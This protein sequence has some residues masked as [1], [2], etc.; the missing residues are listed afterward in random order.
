MEGR[1]KGPLSPVHPPSPAPQTPLGVE[2][3]MKRIAE[4]E[5][6]EEVW[7]LPQSLPTQQLAQMAVEAGPSM[8]CGEEPAR[9]KL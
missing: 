6:L 8:L 5:W 7:R 9:K 1:A 3:I 2:E 4:A